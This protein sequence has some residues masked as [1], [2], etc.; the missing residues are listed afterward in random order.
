MITGAKGR[1]LTNWPRE[2]LDIF[3]Y[4]FRDGHCLLQEDPFPQNHSTGPV[5]D[6]RYV[7]IICHGGGS[8]FLSEPRREDRITHIL[9]IL[10]YFIIFFIQAI[11]KALQGLYKTTFHVEP[12]KVES[13]VSP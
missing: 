4:S 7:I 1:H 10:F 3:N 8:S 12:F 13:W 11:L 9:S 2:T 6:S 5:R